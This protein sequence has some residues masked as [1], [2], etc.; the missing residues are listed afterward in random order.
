MP[1]T[2]FADTNP[3]GPLNTDRCI[4]RRQICRNSAACPRQR[5]ALIALLD[6]SR[7]S[8]LSC[9]RLSCRR[10]FPLR[11]ASTTPRA[12]QVCLTTPYSLNAHSLTA[13]SLTAH[14]LTAPYRWCGPR[15]SCADVLSVQMTFGQLSFGAFSSAF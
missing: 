7:L 11:R 6:R 4:C 8:R 3:G 5:G 10:R 1:K 12:Q 15:S 14:S 9:R 13:H 2:P